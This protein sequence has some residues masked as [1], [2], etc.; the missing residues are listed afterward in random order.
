MVV[1]G[2]KEDGKLLF[3]RYKESVYKWKVI[4]MDGK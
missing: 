1:T 2:G 3:N 4:E